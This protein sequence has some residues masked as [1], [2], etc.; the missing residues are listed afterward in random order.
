[1]TNSF[2]I[3]RNMGK[4]FAKRS[5]D[6]N[7]IHID[8]IVGY[9]SIFGTNICHGVLVLL[10]FLKKINF[11]NFKF[12]TIK[13]RFNK[14]FFY[15]LKISFLKKKINIKKYE[16][17]L[18]QNKLLVASI[19]ID[20]NLKNTQV[21]QSI[22]KYSDYIY[23]EKNLLKLLYKISSYV[24][25]V[26]PGANSL[27]NSISVRYDFTSRD[28]GKKISIKSEL[29]DKRLPIIS[30]VLHFKKF[31]SNFESLKRPFLKN[32]K[33]KISREIVLRIKKIKENILIIGASQGIGR[34]ILEAVK[35]NR[36]IIKIA[37]Y[38]Q[39]MISV[40]NKKVIIK[41]IDIRKDFQKIN[42]IINKYAPI[43]I[44]YFPTTKVF[45]ENKLNKKTTKE[46]ENFYIN[47]PMKILK[48]NNNKKISFFY[49]STKYIDQNK[50]S[51]Y[52][53]IK[54]KAEK[55][56]SYFCKTNNIPIFIHRFPAIN[57]RQSISISNMSNPN[58]FE[59]LQK[60]K[61]YI[62]Q[63]FPDKV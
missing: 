46:Y 35:K 52:S 58:L 42:S 3:N 29:L 11:N 24:G 54:V 43:R 55:K 47:F 8:K 36:K 15:D 7:K 30:N 57:S 50:K 60:N 34:D 23:L 12:Y 26:N 61:N 38:Y 1:M 63:I 33:I 32:K 59:Y 56:I 41:K 16:Y 9:N 44:F 18:F 51:I 19:H 37:S 2:L 45:F 21:L 10:I 14:P 20:M 62:D 5:K 17:Y 53:K 22:K 31:I 40:H 27:I 13:I 39:N 6:F 49:P 4:V 28:R 48:K 25:T